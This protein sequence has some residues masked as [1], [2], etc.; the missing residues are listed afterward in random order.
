M[1]GPISPRPGFP[2]SRPRKRSSFTASCRRE[3]AAAMKKSGKY[4]YYRLGIAPNG[5]W[6]YFLQ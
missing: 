2:R 3:L 4:G 1:C 5:V 6:H